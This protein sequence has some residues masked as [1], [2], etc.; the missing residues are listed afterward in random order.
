[1]RSEL[2][3]QACKQVPNRYLLIKTAVKA[4]RKLHKPHDRI[5]ETIDTTL[6]R[7]AKADPLA[8]GWSHF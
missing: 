7:F 6:A 5:Q 8:I 2:V 3:F 4:T 1:M